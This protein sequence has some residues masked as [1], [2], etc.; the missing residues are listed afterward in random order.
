MP[1]YSIEDHRYAPTQP[2]VLLLR[3]SV[4]TEALNGVSMTRLACHLASE[5]KGES[6][7]NGLIFDDKKA[8]RSL[9][10]GMT[11]QAHYGTYLWH[12]K[13]H[14]VLDRQKGQQYIEFLTPQLKDQLLTLK[15][16]RVS[17]DI[18]KSQ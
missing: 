12:L 4:P 5:F 15:R 8:A 7:I 6:R 14:Y 1:R 3:V 2:A 13:G 18:P 9:A 16:V 11:D 17:I 10:L